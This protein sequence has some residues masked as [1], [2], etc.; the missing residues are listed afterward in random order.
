MD[1]LGLA[2]D[3]PHRKSARIVGDTMGKISSLTV[4]VPSMMRFVHMTEDYSLSLPLVDGHGNFGSIDG[5][6]CG[7]YAVIR[8][9]DFQNRQ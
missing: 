6:E 3:K 2:P 9:Q 5:D 1:E 7:S 8:R 4:T